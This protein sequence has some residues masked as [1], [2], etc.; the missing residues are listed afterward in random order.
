MFRS[1]IDVSSSDSESGSESDEEV[2]I[3]RI[4][5]NKSATKRSGT[6]TRRTPGPSLPS[7]NAS[8]ITASLLEFHYSVRAAEI[9][10][11][12]NRGT[13]SHYDRQSPEAK[14][15]AKKMFANGSQLLASHGMLAEDLHTEELEGA[16]RQYLSGID[17]LG[18]QALRDTGLL[19][20]STPKV[21]L[22]AA[23]AVLNPMSS[24]QLYTARPG[25]NRYATEFTEIRQLGKGGFGTVY[26]VVNFVD[27][28]HYAIKKIGLDPRRL[29]K[30]WQDG[31]QEEIEN[32]LREIRTLASLGQ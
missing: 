17:S 30:R 25:A 23:G 13:G 15:L 32:V 2:E 18:V 24:L 10:N 27:S 28:Q 11:V 29:K 4:S 1:P 5:T 3:S 7:H 19:A 22:E 9:L 20:T 31:G 16:R 6:D 8:L 14:A 26:H 21:A 12:A